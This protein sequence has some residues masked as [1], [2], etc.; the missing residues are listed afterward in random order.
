MRRSGHVLLCGEH[1]Q[2]GRLLRLGNLYGLGRD[3]RRPW[4]RPV[5]QRSLR[6]LRRTWSALLQLGSGSRL[7]LGGNNL[8]RGNL[9]EMRRSRRRLLRLGRRCRHLQRRGPDVQCRRLPEMRRPWRPLLRGQCLPERMLLRRHLHRRSHLLWCWQRHLLG[10]TLHRMRERGSALLREPLLRQADV[11][12][13]HLH[14]V[15]GTG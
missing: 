7:H 9:C 13:Q 8:Q 3:L 12:G 2:S 15:W 11:P 5:Q 10:R 14:L 6:Q 4:R 1:L